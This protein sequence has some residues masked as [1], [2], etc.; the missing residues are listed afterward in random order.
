MAI[1]NREPIMIVL[2]ALVVGALIL[3]FVRRHA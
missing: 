3:I 2:L 1:R